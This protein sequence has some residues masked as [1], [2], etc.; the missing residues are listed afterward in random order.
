MIR[1]AQIG[2]LVA[3]GLCLSAG[4]ASAQ[5]GLSEAEQH[6]SARASELIAALRAESRTPGM[7]AAVALDGRVVWSAGFGFADVEAGAPA[8]GDTVYRLASISKAITGVA[9]A[10]LVQDGLV[11]L[12]AP[13]STYLPDYPTAADTITLRMLMG[14]TSGIRSYKPGYR[15]DEHHV[16]Y[17]TVE[18][19]LARFAAEPLVH[20]PGE[21]FT[22]TT[23]GYIPVRAVIEKVTGK[24]FMD[25]VG[26]TVL[27]PAGMFDTRADDNTAVV[28]GRSAFYWLSPEVD[29]G[30][31]NAL[32]IDTSYKPAGGGMI[33]TAP[34]LCRLA[35]GLSNDTLIERAY[36]DELWKPTVLNSGETRDYGLG[37]GLEESPRGAFIAIQI[38]GQIGTASVVALDPEL[39]AAAAIIAN[40]ASAPTG[41]GDSVALMTLFTDAAAGVPTAIPPIPEGLFSARIEHDGNVWT[42]VLT[43]ATPKGLP[44]G[45]LHVAHETNAGDRRRFAIATATGARDADLR[46]FT[47]HADWGVFPFD[48][49]IGADGSLSG[50]L[51]R[52]NDGAWTLE[53][54]PLAAAALHGAGVSAHAPPGAQR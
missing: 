27:R 29:G 52:T 36:R 26:E 33:G 47:V 25:V 43:M 39:D 7:S 3:V 34:D 9:L 35:M 30:A 38:G 13:L 37:W 40:R 53:A 48:I 2:V 19:A 8:R 5:P 11:D 14:H 10:K 23:L 4:V 21:R 15:D 32:Q 20:E 50:V 16:H 6:A 44:V 12:D 28:R 31:T 17:D 18:Q 54:V 22:Y 1:G 42:G 51:E 49:T 24:D 45:E 41:A 46:L